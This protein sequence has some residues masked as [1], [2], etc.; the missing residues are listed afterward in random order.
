MSMPERWEQGSEYHLFPYQSSD[1]FPAPWGNNGLF[2][3]SGQDAFRSL[4]I[5]GQKER[6]WRRFWIPTYFCQQVVESFLST[7]IEV[8]PYH[9]GPEDGLVQV[10]WKSLNRGDVLFVVNHFGLHAKLPQYPIN[11]DCI[12]VIEDHTHDPWSKWAW[13]SDADW[14]VVS[15]RKT[16]PLPDGGVLW[17]PIGHRLPSKPPVDELRRIASLEKF[18]A[19]TLKTLY[20]QGY[21]IAKE[22]FRNLAISGEKGVSYDPSIREVSGMTVWSH[23]LLQNFPIENW[24][25][26]R[27]DNHR[28]LSDILSDLKWLK[29]LKPQSTSDT[30]PFSC[31]VFFDSPERR[32]YV[33]KELIDSRVY[34]AV[35]WPLDNPAVQGIPREHVEFSQRM[36]SFHCDMR[37]TKKD[38]QHV[39]SLI[40]RFGY[41]S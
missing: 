39:A 11:R 17:S 20:L 37:Y 13:T 18:A 36:L 16:L 15:L 31:I 35:L 24:R 28:L 12:E 10:G 1:D 25:K 14:C 34:P 22:V 33:R 2:S 40:K 7:G 8:L 30:C 27:R 32:D 21:S 6:G 38:I 23:A 3:G 9:A 5:H 41:Y 19:M 26:Q 29:V 4:L